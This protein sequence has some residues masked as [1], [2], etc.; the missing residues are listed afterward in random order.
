MI[1]VIIFSLIFL[2]L[3]FLTLTA[4]LAFLH[5]KPRR[6]HLLVLLL[7]LCA[8]CSMRET[9]RDTGVYID[10]FNEG[11][12]RLEIGFMTLVDLLKKI[13]TAP[14][15]LFFVIALISVGLKLY[16]F[17]LYS[18]FFYPSVF[19][20]LSS[21]FISNDFVAIRSALVMAIGLW[22]IKFC[23]E[24][25][26]I[27][28]CASLALATSFHVT[29]LVLVL[30]W[31]IIHLKINLKKYFWLIPISYLLYFSGKSFGYLANYISIPYVQSLFALYSGE[32][33][34]ELGVV[35][36]FAPTH[37]L[38]CVLC[39]YIIWH[40]RERYL[41]RIYESMLK[42]FCFGISL[43]VLLSDI[44]AFSSRISS[45]FTITAPLLI[46]SLFY[47]LPGVKGRRIRLIIALF[48]IMNIVSSYMN[49]LR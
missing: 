39:M 8:I 44:P 41:E 13:S 21:S 20:F 6:I 29:A 35:N 7:L 34:A 40:C 37:L 18:V 46:G 48:A 45:L 30:I 42:L 15:F 38:N 33:G 9:T 16:F 5:H 25:R 47:L 17:K 4:P 19:I 49:V 36:V 12:A 11:D 3:L 22:M 10:A 1:I 31:P 24:K 32:T 27:L 43:F 23:L 28:F 2:L 14:A 26:W